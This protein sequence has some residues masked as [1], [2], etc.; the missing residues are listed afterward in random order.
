[1][2]SYRL[3]TGPATRKGARG[4]GCVVGPLRVIIKPSRVSDQESAGNGYLL[5]QCNRPLQALLPPGTCRPTRAVPRV[6]ALRITGV[7][8]GAEARLRKMHAIAENCA[9]LQLMGGSPAEHGDFL[10]DERGLP[11]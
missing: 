10:Y 11:K 2:V 1:M 4:V 7:V 3:S 6:S 9:R 5:Q 8:G